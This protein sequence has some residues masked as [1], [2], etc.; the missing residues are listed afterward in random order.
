[1]NRLLCIA[2]R[3]QEQMVCRPEMEKSFLDLGRRR[4]IRHRAA[5]AHLWQGAGN[6]E[7]S[8]N[9]AFVVVLVAAVSGVAAELA[10]RTFAPNAGPALSLVIMALALIGAATRVGGKKQKPE[11]EPVPAPV[12]VKVKTGA[13]GSLAPV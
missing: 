8:V 11:P 12:P 3:R 7:V 5:P 1:M 9:F 10:L 13:G 6:E 4:P 2:W